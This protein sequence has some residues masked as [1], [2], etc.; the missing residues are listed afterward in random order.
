MGFPRKHWLSGAC[1]AA[2]SAALTACAPARFDSREQWT[3]PQG[4]GRAISLEPSQYRLAAGDRVKITV[5]GQTNVTGEYQIDASG[6]VT[7][8][9]ASG[10]IRVKGLTAEKAGRYLQEQLIAANAFRDPRIS[11]ELVSFAPVYVLGEVN[12]PGEFVYRPG[13]SLFS[14]VALAGGYTFRANQNRAFIRA[15]DERIETDYRIKSDITVMPGDVIRV[16]EVSL[17]GGR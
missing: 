2:V 12:R 16:P 4:S 15:S 14:A 8:P 11:V 1:I 10:P 17:F 13:M 9:L 6:S 3:I 5:F 7:I